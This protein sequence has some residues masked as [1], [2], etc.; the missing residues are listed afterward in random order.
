ME[1]VNGYLGPS[2]WILPNRES[3]CEIYPGEK[4]W[5][6]KGQ[7]AKQVGS[8][9][10]GRETGGRPPWRARRRRRRRPSPSRSSSAAARSRW[11]SRPPPPPPTWSASSSRSPTSSPAARGSSA[12]APDSPS[13][14][15]TLDLLLTANLL[16]II[17]FG[18]LS[19]S[20]CGCRESSGGCRQPELDAGGE[21]IQ[22]HAHGLAGAPS[23]GKL[24]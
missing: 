22:G 21:R 17:G 23:G 14:T 2:N 19:F 4:L 8:W 1:G 10:S 7:S 15:Q 18:Y 13:P 6:L 16:P 11:R 9:Q 5:R 20:W 24:N 3:Y 12:K